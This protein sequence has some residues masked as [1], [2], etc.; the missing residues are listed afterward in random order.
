M[1]ERRYNRALIMVNIRD[2]KAAAREI[3]RKFQPERVI[4]FGSYARG[5]ATE[6]SD[7]DLLILINGK[8]VHDQSI[9]ISL[10][11]NFGFPVD[12]VVRSPEEFERRIA[13]GD[14]FLTEISETGKVLYEAAHAR[15][16][17]KSRRRLRNG[18]TRASRA[19]I[20]QLR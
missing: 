6:N 11:I 16:G 10:A 17:R 20:T 18:A 3:A 14:Q 19:K 15:V 4:L 5:N 7:V 2:I 12:L 8:R 9:P 1:I 13:L